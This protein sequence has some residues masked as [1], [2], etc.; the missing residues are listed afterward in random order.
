MRF[1]KRRQMPMFASHSIGEVLRAEL[2]MPRR[3]TI[4]LPPS[5]GGRARFQITA[6][7]L[8]QGFAAQA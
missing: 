6:R 3:S 4:D 2:A 8:L 5:F 7:K 1:K